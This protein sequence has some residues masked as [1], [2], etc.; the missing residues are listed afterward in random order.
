MQNIERDST[1]KKWI[2][3]A[4]NQNSLMPQ[5]E[6]DSYDTEDTDVMPEHNPPL[7]VTH[8][9][10]YY[11]TDLNPDNIASVKNMFDALFEAARPEVD[12]VSDLVEKCTLYLAINYV[13]EEGTTKSI[14]W[15]I[16]VRTDNIY[17]VGF[18][19][20]TPG[21]VFERGTFEDIK[22]RLVDYCAQYSAKP[23]SNYM[24]KKCID[25]TLDYLTK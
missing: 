20:I 14:T 12:S 6:Y 19:T 9:H 2:H 10:F 16:Y 4:T 25:T 24:K 15:R 7:I 22:R 18:V 8:Y 21:K 11:H 17:D 3:A 5:I 23:L 13:D 1:M